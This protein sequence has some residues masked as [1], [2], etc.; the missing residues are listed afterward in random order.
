MVPLRLKKLH[1]RPLVE[2]LFDVVWGGRK[3]VVVGLEHFLVVPVSTNADIEV[4]AVKEFL[5]TQHLEEAVL[6]KEVGRLGFC[7]VRD[8]CVFVFGAPFAF[9]IRIRRAFLC[10]LVSCGRIR[11]K[12]WD[13]AVG[14]N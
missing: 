14:E 7:F 11:K 13:G 5:H 4:F 9:F 1:G 10:A 6:G 3:L 2:E 8:F 12:D